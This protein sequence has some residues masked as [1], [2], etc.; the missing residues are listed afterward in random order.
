MKDAATFS[1]QP[2]PALTDDLFKDVLKTGARDTYEKPFRL[3]TTRLVAFVTAECIEDQGKYLPLIESELNAILGEK[4]WAV[5][6]HVL[7]SKPFGGIDRSID[8]GTAARAWTLATG[9]L[10]ARR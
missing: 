7:L 8:L 6:A 4:S 9:R 1:T 5:P 10:L 2:I 3:R